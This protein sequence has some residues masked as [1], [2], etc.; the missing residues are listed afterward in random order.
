MLSIE[1]VGYV[2]G[3]IEA[4]YVQ[5]KEETEPQIEIPKDSTAYLIV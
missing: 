3:T 1:T 5:K 2:E 4:V